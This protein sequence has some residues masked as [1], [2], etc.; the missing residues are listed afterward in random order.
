MPVCLGINRKL[1]NVKTKPSYGLITK[2]PTWVLN[3]TVC[4]LKVDTK[5]HRKTLPPCGERIIPVIFNSKIRTTFGISKSY[6]FE[7][8]NKVIYTTI[9]R[10]LVSLQVC[11][12][13][14]NPQFVG[15]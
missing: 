5:A 12:L 14:V 3:D 15:I 6:I 4:R 9:G 13:K 8:N 11:I 2:I 10:M 1:S 7:I